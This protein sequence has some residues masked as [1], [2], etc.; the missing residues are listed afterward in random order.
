M[1]REAVGKPLVGPMGALGISRETK[2]DLGKDRRTTIKAPP[3]EM[4]IAV[5]NSSESLPLPSRVRTKTGMASRKRVH[6]RASVLSTGSPTY[7]ISLP[8]SG[9]HLQRSG[10]LD[11]E[12]GVEE[13][14]G[15]C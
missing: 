9:I 3:A 2:A 11:A 4:L 12:G 15:V 7:L 6:F 14:T 10:I 1:T 8:K 13:G 5:A